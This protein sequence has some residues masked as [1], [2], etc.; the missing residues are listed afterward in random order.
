MGAVGEE[1]VE[2]Q[3]FLGQLVEVRGDVGG[4]AQ[5]AHRVAGEALHQDYHDVLDRQAVGRRR[6]EVTAD[7]RA[8][9]I[10]QLVVL[11]QDHVAHGLLGLAL[12]EGSL[13][14]V[15]AV[16]AKTAVGGVDQGQGAVKAQLVD[17]IGVGS[18]RVTP[19]HRR[20]LAQGATGGDHGHQ[21][22][23][24]EYR[25]T[26]VPGRHAAQA[27]DV[28][29]VLAA[30]A[31]KTVDALEQQAQHPGAKGP[32]QQVAHHRKTVPE[33][34]QN[35][36]G[37]FLHI[38]EHQAVEALVKLAVEVHLHQA[39][40]HHHAG[41]QGQPYAKQATGGHGAS[42][43]DRQQQRNA[44]VHHHAQVEAQ[45]VEEAFGDGREWGVADHVAVVEQQRQ[46]HEAQHQHDHQAAQQGIGEV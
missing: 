17:E 9:G 36:L 33:H 4:T 44:Q 3:T 20:A 35:G 39:E 15:A 24:H 10:H 13:P 11:G 1:T 40:E 32:G 14:D 19:T 28:A 38:L 2:Q 27:G 43:E 21:Q 31:G 18:E 29:G 23:H 34:A 7:R 8:V 5:R 41:S 25:A 22:D 46:A 12:V 26:Q 37:V 6:G 42:A 16:F 45:A 30:R